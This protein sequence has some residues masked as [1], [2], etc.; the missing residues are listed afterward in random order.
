MSA[1]LERLRQHGAQQAPP[2]EQTETIMEVLNSLR[3]LVEAQNSRLTVLAERQQKLTS[4]VKIMDEESS[5]QIES[6]EQ[7]LLQSIT[8]ASV[9]GP[10][11]SS[12]S[13]SM[14]NELHEIGQTLSSLA[15][16]IDGKQIVGA[17]SSLMSAKDQIEKTTAWNSNQANVFTRRYQQALNAGGKAIQTTADEAV[18][19]IRESTASAAS[20]ASQQVEATTQRVDAAG[21]SAVRTIET[22]ERLQKS[23]GWAAAGHMSLALLPV[24]VVLLMGVQTVWALVVGIHWALAQDWALWLDITAGIGLAGLITGAGFG[25]CRLT[26]WVKAALD[27]AVMR[28][29]R[30]RR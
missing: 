19:A 11:D 25:L 18:T 7:R 10:S 20:A 23:L 9:P 26:V 24:V 29:G 3:V 21:K 8:A 12:M 14:R 27:R 13:E 22:A 6:L 15:E 28:S 1:A 5:K 4:Y 17:V 2:V 30:N 16:A